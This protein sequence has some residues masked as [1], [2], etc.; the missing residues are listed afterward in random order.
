MWNLSTFKDADDPTP[1]RMGFVLAESE[2]HAAQIAGTLIAGN[3]V[4]V[5]LV[6]TILRTGIRLQLGKVNWQDNSG[7]KPRGS[8]AE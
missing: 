4:R 7:T 5:E 2:E 1:N 6:R 3:E 8:V